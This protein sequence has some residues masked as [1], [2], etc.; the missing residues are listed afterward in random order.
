MKHDRRRLRFATEGF[1]AQMR[2]EHLK[3]NP[4]AE[5]PQWL[6]EA[7]PAAGQEALI[8]AIA[9]AVVLLEDRNTTAYLNWC[10]NQDA[11]HNPAETP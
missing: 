9:A 1:L 2:R 5:A 7:Y 10:A 11:R 3:A 6:L 8:N 4:G